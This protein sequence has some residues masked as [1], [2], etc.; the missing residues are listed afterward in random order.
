MTSPERCRTYRQRLRERAFNEIGHRCIFCRA[1][2]VDAAHV[3]PTKLS[4]KNSRGMDRRYRDVI[5]NPDCYRPMCRRCHLAYDK[6]QA[7]LGKC[8]VE[9]EPIPF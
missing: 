2:K 7:S 6:L 9:E 5:Q 4:G 1:S 8:H 3:M